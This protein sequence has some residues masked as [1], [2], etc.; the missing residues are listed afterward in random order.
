MEK[1]IA[2]VL[3]M[4]ASY[5]MAEPLRFFSPAQDAPLAKWEEKSFEGATR[6][7]LVELNKQRVLKASSKASA[8]GLFRKERIN[9]KEFPYLNWRWQAASKL[10]ELPETKKNGDDYVARVYVVRSGGWFFW[11]TMALNYVWSSRSERGAIW[12]NAFAPDNARMVALRTAGD[13]P[14]QWYQEKRN[15]YEDFKKWLGEDVEY[16]DAVAIM[17]DTD[18]SGSQAEAYYGEIFFTQE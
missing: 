16:I 9:I 3:L 2:I 1:L 8:S 17:T 11:E 18:N 14:G 6:Y 5:C 12:P 10:A 15:V 13:E 7:Q 4:L